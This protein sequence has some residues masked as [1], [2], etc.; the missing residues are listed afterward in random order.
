[1]AQKVVTEL[2]DDIDGSEADETLEFSYRGYSYE[3]DLNVK[4]IAKLDK[5]LTPFIEHA[6]RIGRASRRQAKA[7]VAT[8]V[9][10]DAAAVRV[11]AQ[12]NGYEVPVRGRIPGTVREAYEAAHAS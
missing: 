4:N 6:R 9:P 3:I 5:T 1:M 12:S 10:S 11:W 2:L 7:A 8:R